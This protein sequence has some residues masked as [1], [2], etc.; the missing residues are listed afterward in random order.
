M[1]IL[2]IAQYFP[3][4]V[5]NLNQGYDVFNFRIHFNFL[6]ILMSFDATMRPFTIEFFV[7]I[8]ATQ[9]SCAEESCTEASVQFTAKVTYIIRADGD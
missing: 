1:L 6:C 2:C 3:L 5:G 9:R 8:S 4:Y 7:Q